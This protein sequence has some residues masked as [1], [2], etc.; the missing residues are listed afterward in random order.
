[1]HS[2]CGA[3]AKQNVWAV[4]KGVASLGRVL[5][6]S[7]KAAADLLNLT[8][9]NRKVLLIHSLAKVVVRRDSVESNLATNAIEVVDG[10][11]VE[12]DIVT[13]IE[14]RIQPQF[15]QVI[16]VVQIHYTLVDAGVVK[17]KVVHLHVQLERVVGGRRSDSHLEH[18]RASSD[19]LC[20]ERGHGRHHRS[21][22][23]RV[24]ENHRIGCRGYA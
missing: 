11:I 18:S 2:T 14:I 8:F 16:S 4:D 21:S 15:T 24:E 9:A 13:G 17:G 20:M 7:S 3:C 6:V 12:V 5:D 1:M 22:T 19:I 10:A 23:D